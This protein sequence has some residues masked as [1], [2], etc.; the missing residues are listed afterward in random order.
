MK[1]LRRGQI[2]VFVPLLTRRYS[3]PPSFQKFRIV[4]TTPSLVIRR[5]MSCCPPN[6]EKY[7]APDYTAVGKIT[8]LSE[9]VEFYETGSSSSKNAVIVIPDIFGW[10]GGRTRNIADYLAD[11][12]YYTVVPKLLSPPIG[13]GTDG[14][15]FAAFSFDTFLADIV[16]F[17]FEGT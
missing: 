14:D 6:A 12:G 3:T 9:G 1:M 16:K 8:A 7:L 13:G 10:N 17:P 11:Q 2:Q 5:K 15:G 4:T